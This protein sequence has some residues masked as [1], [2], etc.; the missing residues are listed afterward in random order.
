MLRGIDGRLTVG[1][2]LDEEAMQ[3]VRVDQERE[4]G[5]G[6]LDLEEEHAGEKDV[7]EVDV[8]A[9]A[10]DAQFGVLVSQFEH[11]LGAVD[12]KRDA[13]RVVDGVSNSKHGLKGERVQEE[14]GGVKVKEEVVRDRFA[15]VRTPPYTPFVHPRVEELMIRNGSATV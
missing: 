14:F 2:G 1:D 7:E 13:F 11:G 3:V 9:V 10:Q 15:R 6:S 12:R 8:R 4:P 5:V